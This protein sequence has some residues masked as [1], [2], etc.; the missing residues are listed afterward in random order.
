MPRCTCGAVLIGEEVKC[1]LC[2][3][4]ERKSSTPGH[5]DQLQ[6]PAPPADPEVDRRERERQIRAPQN[7]TVPLIREEFRRDRERQLQTLQ[8]VPPAGPVQKVQADQVPAPPADPVQKL[9]ATVD[10]EPT[11]LAD[12]VPDTMVWLAGHAKCANCPYATESPNQS[13]CE[14][15]G[16]CVRM[17]QLRANGAIDNDIEVAT[18]LKAAMGAC[19]S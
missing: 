3:K 12:P 1:W 10:S 11:P 4:T 18:H 2:T 14:V 5:A 19:F 9:T 8:P 6:V 7:P 13:Y 17:L 15:C 16:P